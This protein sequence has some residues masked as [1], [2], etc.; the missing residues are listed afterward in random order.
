MVNYLSEEM[1]DRIENWIPTVPG[2][3]KILKK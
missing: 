3:V 2:K 1:E